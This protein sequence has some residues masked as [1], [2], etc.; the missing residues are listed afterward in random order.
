MDFKE[1]TTRQGNELLPEGTA[2]TSVA[3]T[4]VGS[5]RVVVSVAAW[6]LFAI[7]LI[8]CAS[9]WNRSVSNSDHELKHVAEMLEQGVRS[10][11]TNSELFLRTVGNDLVYNDL[12]SNPAGAQEYLRRIELAQV[13]VIG[14]AFV[15][16]DGDFLVTSFTEDGAT[17]PALREID[18]AADDFENALNNPHFHIAQPYFF[19]PIGRWVVPMRTPIF[20]DNGTLFGFMSLVFELERGLTLSINMAAPEGIQVSLVRPDHYLS[21]IYPLVREHTEQTLAELYQ[22]QISPELREIMRG[23]EGVRQYQRKID[24]DGSIEQAYAYVKPMP[25]YNLT[26]V[27]MSSRTK[28]IHQWLFSLLIPFAVLLSAYIALWF[29]A[30]RARQYLQKAEQEINVRQGALVQSLE[31]Y[32]KLTSLIPAGVYQLRVQN[33]GAR[34]CYYLSPRTRAMFGVPGELPLSEALEYIVDLIHPD[35]IESFVETEE[36]AI[37]RDVPFTWQGRFRVKGDVI[38]VN[39]HSRPS[40]RDGSGKAWHGVALDVTEQRRSQQQIEELSYYDALTH[41]PNRGLL[42]QRIASAITSAQTKGSYAGL[43]SIDLDNF[44]ILNNSLGQEDGDRVLKAVG[45]RFLEIVSNED[46]V[47]RLTADEFVILV[48]NAGN[49]EQNALKQVLLLV[50]KINHSMLQ[51]FMLA[52]DS[53]M[54]TASIGVTLVTPE[55][56]S[57]ERLLQ[58]ADQAMFEAK[59]A[60]RNT[61]VIFNKD[62]EARMN[63]RLELQRD[64]H[65]GILNDELELHYQPKVNRYSETV[66]VEALVRWRHPIRGMVSPVDFISVAEQSADI[67]LLGNWVL[68]TACLKLLDWANHET[69]NDWTMSVNV[70]VKELRADNF[71]EQVLHVLD[72]TGARAEKLILEITES[73]LIGDTEHAIR[74]MM[75]LRERGVRFS[76]DDFGTGYSNLSYLQ[77]LPLDQLKIDRSFV[78]APDANQ[79]ETLTHRKLTQGIISLGHTLDLIVVAQGVETEDQFNALLEQGCDIFQGYYFSPPVRAAKL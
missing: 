53:Y 6:A 58:Q 73:M 55:S 76:L 33:D 46:T 77:R 50:D 5:L 54:L 9:L 36:S 57:V 49:S 23:G 19:A 40:E 48:G 28:V 62:I 26:A 11:F 41:L 66:G 61:C 51:P 3:N 24:R 69:R 78:S 1:G 29:A 56:D 31:R 30:W 34:E 20:A 2:R 60:G 74:K 7:F 67:I 70:S 47:S 68:R 63:A 35:D 16:A 25:E 18:L 59:D 71:V 10:H 43:L 38:W 79:E 39:I 4:Y 8:V 52:S 27:A 64:L 12:F 17:L 42:H 45:E 21:Y 14:L 13:G 75:A 15:T 32:G 72:E 44:K 22:A 37:H 65:R